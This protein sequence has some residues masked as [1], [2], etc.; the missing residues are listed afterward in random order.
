MH[1]IG[2]LCLLSLR[3]LPAAA[4][5]A[6]WHRG[7]L[8]AGFSLAAL[9]ALATLWLQARR[10]RRQRDVTFIFWR[11]AMLALLA[12]AASWVVF[13]A[14]PQLGQ[15]A[16]SALWLGVLALPGVFLS[17]IM[18]MLYKIMPFLNWLH[19][20]QPGGTTVPLPNM[21]QM[22]PE[23][24]MRVQMLLHFTALAV[25]LAAVIW[26]LLALPAGLA[27]SASCICLEWN[28]IVA[29]RVFLRY[30]TRPGAAAGSV[31][32]AGIPDDRKSS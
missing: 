5:V 4:G 23:R 28:L 2:L 26:P 14:W 17:V 15:Q 20:Q 8:L 7:A 22:I 6:A 11:G 12:L 3:L 27:F 24:A 9:Y 25:L 30:R 10:R 16:R 29:T 13:Q 21:K 32:T 1:P 31:L 19:L 18:G